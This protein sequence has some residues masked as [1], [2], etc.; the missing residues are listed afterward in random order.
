MAPWYSYSK[1]NELE[2]NNKHWIHYRKLE[3]VHV[4]FFF[5][6]LTIYILNEIRKIY[7]YIDLKVVK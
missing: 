1:Y 3:Y 5:C 4:F 7:I 2:T 6:K